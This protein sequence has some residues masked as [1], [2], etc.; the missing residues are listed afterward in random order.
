MSLIHVLLHV[1]QTTFVFQSN[2][3]AVHVRTVSRLSFDRKLNAFLDGHYL[4]Q[5]IAPN[6]LAT[7]IGSIGAESTFGHALDTSRCG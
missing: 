3:G 2:F 5:P 6:V 1:R 7:K 4:I